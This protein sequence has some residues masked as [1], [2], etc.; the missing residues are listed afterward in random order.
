VKFADLT[1]TDRNTVSEIA[2]ATGSASVDAVLAY[3]MGGSVA[4]CDASALGGVLLTRLGAGTTR[5]PDGRE[6]DRLR[7]ILRAHPD[8]T[9]R[10]HAVLAAWREAAPQE[11]SK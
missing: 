11:K 7:T 4:N 3:L 5:D 8:P 2:G 9:D 1:E 10:L 6:W